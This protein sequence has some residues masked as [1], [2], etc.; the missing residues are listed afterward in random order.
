MSLAFTR[1]RVWYC[2][3]VLITTS[4][5]GRCTNCV[6]QHVARCADPAYQSHETTTTFL[7]TPCHIK[8]CHMEHDSEIAM[9]ISYVTYGEIYWHLEKCMFKAFSF[10][11]N[12]DRRQLTRM[13]E[14]RHWPQSTPFILVSSIHCQKVDLHFECQHKTAN[15][16]TIVL[17]HFANEMLSSSLTR[18]HMSILYMWHIIKWNAISFV[19]TNVKEND[20]GEIL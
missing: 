2:V 11:K 13:L 6:S 1:C 17:W 12:F 9:A 16:S 14:T 4:L 20:S 19:Q 15:W 3:G 8:I 7:V 5:N 10:R 18:W